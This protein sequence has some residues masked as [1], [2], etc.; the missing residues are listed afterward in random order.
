MKAREFQ[1]VLSIIKEWYLQSFSALFVNGQLAIQDTSYKLIR[2]V[3]LYCSKPQI[4]WQLR[5]ALHAH[6]SA[7]QVRDDEDDGPGVDA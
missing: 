5:G 1:V 7:W 6:F 2:Y 3:S 4:E